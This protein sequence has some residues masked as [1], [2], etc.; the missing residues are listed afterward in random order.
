MLRSSISGSYCPSPQFIAISGGQCGQTC[1]LLPY[2]CMPTYI[3]CSLFYV[4]L[5]KETD[6]YRVTS[7]NSSTFWNSILFSEDGESDNPG[8]NRHNVASMTMVYRTTQIL[9]KKANY[10]YAIILPGHKILFLLACIRSI[11]GAMKIQSGVRVLLAIVASLILVY[12]RV[13]FKILSQF[14]D[15]SRECLHAWKRSTQDGC[16]KR[17]LK[18][19]QPLKMQIG[20]FYYVDRGMVLT[21]FSI[22]VDS[23]V[24]LLLSS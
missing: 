18:S 12:L 20:S 7:L 9:H 22:I 4:N 3:Q 11:Y 15:L 5:G 2:Q 17:S 8:R 23:T 16:F 24:S 13:T 21:L 6:S 10:V 14:F 1:T 19:C